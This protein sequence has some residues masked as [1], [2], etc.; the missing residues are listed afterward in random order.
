M[1][2]IIVEFSQNMSADLD[3]PEILLD[4]HN[5]L[6]AQG[7]DKARIKT[8]ALPLLHSVVTTH[9]ANE[10]RMVH[11]TL[12]LLEGRDI[13][14]RQSMGKALYDVLVTSFRTPFP[15]CAVSL[16]VREMV[17]DTYFQ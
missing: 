8:R 6:A 4:L 13:P 14:L 10:G 9:D 3:I 7:I 12:R 1:P 5:A 15:D 17:K 16:E 11:G 2:H